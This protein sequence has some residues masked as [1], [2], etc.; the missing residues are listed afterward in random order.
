MM[1][2]EKSVISLLLKLDINELRP[3]ISYEKGPSYHEVLG[4]S[5]EECP[6]LTDILESLARKGV[7]KKVKVGTIPSCPKC[8]SHR[9]MVKFLCPVCGST[10]IRRVD[11]I[12]HLPCGYTAPVEKFVSGGTL[13]CP[14]CGKKL[15]AIGVDYNKLRDVILCEDCGKVS[16]APKLMF[17]CADCGAVFGEKDVAL[18]PIYGYRVL[19]EKLL[20]FRPIIGE[21]TVILKEKGLEVTTPK[22]VLGRSGI[23]HTFS[24]S[25][26]EGRGP[27][28]LIDVVQRE[29]AV[30]DKDALLVVAKKM[31]THA[32]HITLVA[33]PRASEKAKALA[34]G[35]NI[36]V[37]EASDVEEAASKIVGQVKGK[38]GR[39]MYTRSKGRAT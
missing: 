29:D 26:K 23:I 39:P 1:C 7:L 20:S 32:P 13:V 22:E 35:F 12:V 15:K 14:K 37:V 30:S 34:R 9:I 38:P 21:L 31:D 16:L 24:M 19:K 25:V 18:K 5:E 10:N 36:N 17:E 28:H 3:L 27:E 6:N 2:D 33:M 8:G 11:A 4:I